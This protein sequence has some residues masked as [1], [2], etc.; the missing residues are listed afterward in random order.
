MRNMGEWKACLYMRRQGHSIIAHNYRS[1]GCEIDL[2]TYNG[3]LRFVEVKAWT[4]Q[5][6]AS[7]H[8]ADPLSTQHRLRRH[9]VRQTVHPFIREYVACM[10]R[11]GHKEA[12]S[13]LNRADLCI[14]FDLLWWKRDGPEYFESIF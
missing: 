12:A 11:T 2:I 6:D 10:E 3:I 7:F 4:G 9:K 13:E 14:S 5:A 1:N 8:N